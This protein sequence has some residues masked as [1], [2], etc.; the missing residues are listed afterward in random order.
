[1]EHRKRMASPVRGAA[2]RMIHSELAFFYVGPMLLAL[3]SRTL[4]R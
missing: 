1:M 4:S 3:D 2:G